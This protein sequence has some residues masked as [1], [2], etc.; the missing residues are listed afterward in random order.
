MAFG[1]ACEALRNACAEAFVRQ[2]ERHPRA[3]D[4]VSPKPIGGSRG[5]R[6]DGDDRRWLLARIAGQPDLTLEELRRELLAERG[7][8]AGYGTL[9]RFCEREK[10][11]FKKTL[12]PTQQERPDVAEARAARREA[13]PGCDE[14]VEELSCRHR[15]RLR[16]QAGEGVLRRPIDRHEEV[17]LTFLGS[18]LGD[19]WK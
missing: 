13:Q 10:L 17:E 8:G 11:T 9:W 15:G 16:F 7:L 19:V 2:L 12:H 18:D 3:T 4:S 6:I 5:F 14:F 1:R